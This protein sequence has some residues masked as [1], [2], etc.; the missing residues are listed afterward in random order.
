MKLTIALITAKAGPQG[1]F[2]TGRDDGSINSSSL[3]FL[4]NNVQWRHLQ[5]TLSTQEQECQVLVKQP[6]DHATSFL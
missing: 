5:I 3:L 4:C 2:T 6:S 1:C